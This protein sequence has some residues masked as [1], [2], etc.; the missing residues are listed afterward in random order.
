[1]RV[2]AQA[3]ASV[4]LPLAG[5]QEGSPGGVRPGCRGTTMG[6]KRKV[7]QVIHSHTEDTG[8]HEN[9]DPQLWSL[10]KR[11]RSD[12]EEKEPPG[13]PPAASSDSE[14]SH[15]GDRWTFGSHHKKEQGKARKT[16]PQKGA[17]NKRANTT[18]S[19]GSPDKD[20]SAENQAPE[21]GGGS[22]SVS[23]GS[24]SSSDSDSSSGDEQFHDGYGE[25]LMGDEGDRARLR[26]MTEKQREQ[27]LFNRLEKR[28]VLQRR[29]EIKQKLKTAKK[30]DK[31]EKK[32]KQ[33]EEQ[34]K[35]K[36]TQIPESRVTSHNKG[37]RSRREEKRD[38][39]AQALEELT[40][41]RAKGKGSTA[42][43][44]ANRQPFPTREVYADGE[45]EGEDDKPSEKS[46]HSSQT[47]S[48]QEEEEPGAVPPKAQPVSLPEEL[49]RVRL[50]RQK[51]EGWCHMPF[52]AQTVTG[53]FVRIGIGN[54]NSKP[55]YR[56][57][58]ITGVV[59]TANVYQLGGSR[60]NKGLQLRHGRDQR[61]FRLE[62]VSNQAFTESEFSKWKDAML[63]AGMHLPTLEELQK[64]EFSIQEA[65]H[66]PFSD[67]DIDE[68]VKEKERFRKAPLNY[69][70]WKTRLLK[71]KA[72]AE[73]LGHQDKAQQIQAQL[74]ELEERA[75]ALD[76]RRTQNLAAIG[77]I[78]QRN[79]EW[80]I[81]ASAKAL[82]A[83]SHNRKNQPM[84]PFTRR[85]CKPTLVPHSRDPA[86]AVQTAISAQLNAKYGSGVLPEAPRERSQGRD[87]EQ[88]WKSKSGSD[89]SED[90]YKVHDFELNVDVQVPSAESK[91]WA[92]T[93]KAPPAKHGA[94]RRSL[95]L[96]DYKK[97]RGKT[98]QGRLHLL[99]RRVRVFAQAA[100]SVGLPLAGRQEGSP[101]G[102]RPG[103]RGTT[104]GKKRKVGQV[105]HSHTEDTGSHENLDPQLWS[106]A[107]RKRSDS[108]EKEPPGSPPAASSD[109]ETS[110]TGDRWT[111]GSHHKKEQG[112]A[113]KTPP[114]KG[115][116]NKR[117]NT[118]ASSG[119][120]DKD[121]SAE[122]QAPEQGGGSESVSSGSSSSSD[123]D[124][125]SGDEQFHDGYGEDLMGDEGDRARLRQMT[126]KQREQ[127]LFN[128][129]EKREVLQR[130]FE[131]KQ[132][133]K[134]AKKKD[135]EEKK[136]KQEEEQEKTKRTQIPESR[137]TSHNK[138]LRSRREEKRDK[139][140]QAL[141]EL[142]AER[143]KGKGSTAELLANRQ[144]FPTREVY[145]DGEEEGEDD[146]PSEKSDHSS[147]TSS[148]QEE[149]EPGAVPPKAQPVSLP[150]E[151]NRVRL[152]RQKLEGWCHMPFFAQTVT[153]CFV[154]I[155]IGNH[156]S[157]PVY[158]V[159]EITG[160]VETANVYQLGGS[161]TNKGLQLRHGRDQRV[162]RLEFVSKQAF[163]ESEFSKWKDA[164]LSAGM[165]LPTLEELQK[166][167]F[168]IQEALHYPFSDRDID[169]IVKEKERFRKAPLNYAMWKTRLLKEKAMAEDLGHQDKA[170]QIQ[171]QLHELEERAGALDRRR[172]QNLAAIGD[173]NQRNRE[174]NILA[175][176]KALVAESHNRKNQPMDP[177]T[178]R[179]CKPT[180]VPHSRDPAAAVQT[181]I[182]AQL[183]AKYGSGVLPEA[184]R[185]RSQGRDTEQGWKSK[186]GSDLSEDLYKVHDFELNV[187]V[188]VPSAESKTWAMTAK[189]PPA[190]H[191]A[192]RRS[193]NLEDYKKQRG[194]TSQGRLHLLGRRVRVFAQAAASVG[195]PLAGRQEGSP[196]GVRPGCRGTTMGKKRKVGQVIHSHTEDTGSHE[197]LDPQLWSL[198]KRKRSD[199]EE[200]EPPGSPPAASS[201]SETSHT[202]DRWTFGS[203]HKKEQGKARKTPPQKGA[204]N[205]RANTTASSGSPDK[206]TSAE[207]QAPEQGGGSESVSSGSSSSSDSDS[208]SGDEQFHDG[209]GEDLMGDE[210]DR[211]R[212]RQ[213]TEKQREQELFNRLEKR[214]VLQRRFEIK[215]KLKTA[216]KK[217][218]EEKKKKQEEEQEKT[219]RTQIPESRVTSHNKGLRSRREEK[220]DKQAQ[221]LE[222]LTA[223]RAKGKGS[224]AELLANRQPFPTREVYADGEEEGE[225]DKPSEKS[226]H[227]SQTSSSQEEEE[228]GAVP[229]KA[230][231]VSLPEE[232]NRVRLSRQKLEGWCH[233]PFFAQTVTGCFVRIGIGNHNSKPVYRVAEITGVVETANVYQLGGSRTNKGLQLRHGR[234]QRV[235]RLE[236][237]SNQAFTE[238][239]FSK[240]K[241]AML[242]AGMH[243]PTLE[244]LQKKEFSIQEALHY[245]FSDRDIDEIVKEKERFRKAPLNYA[246]WKT[247]LLKEKAMAE[248]LGHQ[249]KAQQIQ[250]QLHELEERAGALDRRRT[251]NLAAIGDINQRNREWNILAS[252]KALVA[253]S[254]NRKNQPMD[255]FTR[256]QCKP[257]LVPHSRDP[258]AAVQTAISAQLNAKYGSGVLP[259]AP[260]ERSQGRDTEQGWKSKSGSDLSE[261]LYK[262][263]DFELNVDVQVPSAESK[264]WAMT[265][266]APPAKHGAPRRSLNLEDYKKQRGLF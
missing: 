60:T 116:M 68:I 75:G 100:A 62:F 228:P 36:R 18:A 138:G 110:H 192:P 187:D 23:S 221:A 40:A 153:G 179:Q 266:K 190:K 26:Q 67:R 146:K 203:H 185:E 11:K 28:E 255:P 220:R 69:A 112:K 248:D 33:E 21:Q 58:E 41:E 122:N 109:S 264:T 145:A 97:Q 235:F 241:D 114:Q 213:M 124:S 218:K 234:D 98:S 5:R 167:E 37:L 163:T 243:L 200:K 152:S 262:V 34:E 195:L 2:F 115:A 252:A 186:S 154:R 257:T 39:Q 15:T 17:M 141:E 208:S 197:N 251:Q 157:K 246:M 57:A 29:F 188:Q 151:L 77:D 189:A 236:F 88:G 168:S 6:K 165:H 128:R 183:N 48:S 181:A 27:E 73:D 237:V 55:V 45:E 169:E 76:R 1:V 126:E 245:P 111:F 135:K 8:S 227:S 30:K 20:T 211:A 260:R 201:D 71:E 137:V 123:S 96:E 263:H 47:S 184:P 242:S 79:R 143:A 156:N 207:N 104:M 70:M 10:A 238:S 217:D 134:T 66:Y 119:S 175:S 131:I 182:S 59:E 80:N 173:I 230:Q 231:P 194:K 129:L 132:K 144:P 180:L 253:E 46:D 249:D 177:F 166:K 105:I 61:V 142:T 22:E 147:Q 4:G 247:R 161:R 171:A 95:N 43:L 64:K 258:A 212:L 265:A 93:A 206:D 25:D 35:T 56:V 38:K 223:E 196:G 50:S 160:V 106:L 101:G 233:M 214:E 49:N 14:T 113:R 133:L 24:S 130:R 225:D 256:R 229:P 3:A 210:G 92:M 239:E 83:E 209:Y 127:E 65:L 222:E 19:S 136:K 118:T 44:L 191:G 140:A 170:Q 117:A 53:C 31:E 139:Q 120:P 52:F 16:P 198:A 42:E 219:K 205:K 232:L 250:A 155:G 84:D 176:A 174:W 158:R 150:E 159:A 164:M 108:E 193:L 99:G 13:S 103:C 172:T 81:L 254:H 78:N 148:S 202:G 63:S 82:V 199:S 51:L 89:L 149:E 91:T 244:E 224:T 178:R 261:D 90:L 72:M 85:Q 94:P 215:Q 87:T 240:W 226:D 32:K 216:K 162:F 74:H 107:K 7:G 86:A 102:V 54:H 204:M 259:E 121:T 12:S 125:S 9:L